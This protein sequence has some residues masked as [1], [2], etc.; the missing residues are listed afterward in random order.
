MHVHSILSALALS[1]WLGLPNAAAADPLEP[2]K[3]GVTIKRV[4]PEVE[5]HSMHSYFSTCPESPDGKY[6]LFFTSK[7]ADGQLGEVRL[8]ERATG[9][10]RVLAEKVHVE[11]AHRVAC[12]QWVSQG[13]RVVYHGQRND[14]WYVA[15]VDV[16]TGE[17]RIVAQDRLAGWGQPHSD[18]VPLYG[19]HWNPGPHRNLELL[20]VVTGEIRTVLTAEA[21]AAAY[22]EKIKAAFGERPISIFFSTLSPNEERIFFKLASDRKGLVCY[23]LAEKKFLFMNDRWGHPSWHHNSRTI[24]ELGNQLFDSNNGE[25]TRIADLPKFRGDH[26]SVSPNGQL[27]VTDTTMDRLGGDAKHWAVV[28]FDVRGKSHHIVHQFDHSQGAR[29]WRPSHP[30]P[31]FSPDGRRIYFNTSSGPWT[32]LHVAELPE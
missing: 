3:T 25:V 30:H 16:A 18:I 26:P 19:L 23:S 21:V 15:C 2:W 32:Q 24:V 12:Q 29:S 22:P 20:N 17:Q 14:Q 11:D 10:E 5:Q 6:V 28:L 9:K 7:A 31:Y 27:I 1:C 13:K 4:S 8:R